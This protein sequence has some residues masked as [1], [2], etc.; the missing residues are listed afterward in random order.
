[1]LKLRVRTDTEEVVYTLH[2][3]DRSRIADLVAE[4]ATSVTV[5]RRRVRMSDGS[6]VTFT[7][8]REAGSGTITWSIEDAPGTERSDPAFVAE[9]N[10][11]L[12]ELRAQAGC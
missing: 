3:L 8:T 11:T 9:L 4:L 10:A 12:R 7:A 1:V 6:Q 5:L 2:V